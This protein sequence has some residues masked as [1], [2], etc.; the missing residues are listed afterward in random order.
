MLSRP[1]KTYRRFGAYKIVN[2]VN[3]RV[4]VGSTVDLSKRRWKH[5]SELKLNRHYSKELQTDYNTYGEETFVFEVLEFCQEA[6][7]VQTEQRYIDEIKPY[8][9]ACDHAG[10]LLG[11]K[12]P[13]EHK[14]NLSNALKGIKRPKG[15]YSARSRAVLQLDEKNCI[16]AKFDALIEAEKQLGIGYANISSCCNGRLKKVGGYKWMYFEDYQA[17]TAV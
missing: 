14:K 13:E 6:D 16:I 4:Y 10:S 15:K 11:Y 9:N 1:T 17:K 12:F 2:S 8:Y 7:L 5:E 3:Q